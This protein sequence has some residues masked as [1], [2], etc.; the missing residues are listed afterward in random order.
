MNAETKARIQAYAR[1]CREEPKELLCTLGQI[2][3]PTGEEDRRA[4]F[5]RDWL[6]AQGAEQVTMDEAKNVIC[7][8]GD[9][10]AGDL[11]VFAAHTD[12]VF[13]DRDPL[14]MEEREGR[15][16]AP[17]IGDDTANLVNLLLAARY[18]I[19]NHVPT[20]CGLLIVA[21]SCEEGLGNL[22]GT[23]ALFARYG[24]RIR[25]FY[26]FDLYL[27]LCCHTAVGSYRYRVT[28]KTRG[29]H[30]YGDFGR[31]SAVRILCG[32]VDHRQLHPPG[33]VHPL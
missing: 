10:G 21:N 2:P 18:L 27:P 9:D 17:G 4:V 23:K 14:P 32:L 15:L 3:S 13:P 20:T 7:P 11:V 19:R 33:G 25:A 6:L 12:V 24:S 1:S 5:C 8:I 29:G 22:K 28:C 26:S 31:P 16:Y 30:S